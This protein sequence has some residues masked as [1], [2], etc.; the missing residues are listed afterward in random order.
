MG[1]KACTSGKAERDKL[2]FIQSR[3]MAMNQ[4]LTRDEFYADISGTNTARPF[5]VFNEQIIDLTN[6][7]FQNQNKLYL[8]SNQTNSTLQIRQ[9][10]NPGE[11]RHSSTAHSLDELTDPDHFLAVFFSSFKCISGFQSLL[12]NTTDIKYFKVYI[13]YNVPPEKLK[14]IINTKVTLYLLM[15]RD[16]L[17]NMIESKYIPP[18]IHQI[19]TING[20]KT[21]TSYNFKPETYL[22]PAISCAI[23]KKDIEN[24]LQYEL[25]QYQR[26]NLE[27][28]TE[29]EL[30]KPTLLVSNCE[31]LYKYD[32]ASINETIY[33]DPTNWTLYNAQKLLDSGRQYTI[34]LRGGILSD[35]MGLGKT[36]STFSL[37]LNN[38][39]K[40]YP[41]TQV[42]EVPEPVPE[43]VPEKPKRGRKKKTDTSES[44][45]EPLTNTEDMNI[46]PL[47]NVMT[48]VVE[49]K[50]PRK[51]KKIN[52]TTLIEATSHTMVMKNDKTC[53]RATLIIAP[54]RLCKQWYDEINR[55]VKNAT[56]KI[57]VLSTI[58]NMRQCS[59]YDL[60]TADIVIIPANSFTNPNYQAHS[61]QLNTIY[62]H[63]VVIDEA[64]E[65]LKPPSPDQSKRVTDEETQTVTRVTTKHATRLLCEYLLSIEGEYKWLLTGTP[66]AHHVSGLHMYMLYLTQYNKEYMTLSGVDPTYPEYL[67]SRLYSYTTLQGNIYTS[68]I[69]KF[70]RMNTKES[71]K[72]EV[73]IPPIIEE[74]I[75]LKQTPIEKAIYDAA[76]G[77]QKRQ[78]QLCTHVLISEYDASIL[79]TSR[80]LK[81]EDMKD[82]LINHYKDQ[83]DRAVDLLAKKKEELTEVERIKSEQLAKIE[84]SWKILT[85][86]KAIKD[87][88]A[89]YETSR[90]KYDQRIDDCKR[91][92][93]EYEQSVRENTTRYNIFIELNKQFTETPDEPCSIC[94]E[95]MEQ[96]GVSPCGHAFCTE[97]FE[98]LWSK[99]HGAKKIN[100]PMCRIPLAKSDIQTIVRVEP[101]QKEAEQTQINKYGTKMAKLLEIIADVLMR[102]PTNRIILFSQW[103]KM[104]NMVGDVLEEANIRHVYVKGN[105]HVISNAIRRFKLDPS[106]R[107]IMLS[108]ES[109]SSGSNLTEANHIILLDTMNASKE[110]AHAIENQAVGRVSRIG[111]KQQV[112]V[113]RMIMT[114]T[115]EHE[116]YIRNMDV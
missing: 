34:P 95:P 11:T 37:M 76:S 70:I 114:N 83:K 2:Q 58:V 40:L 57:I 48:N 9:V 115:I 36:L 107:I 101:E 35:E 50:K 112:K 77:D 65:I 86:K 59:L 72:Q 116:F 96:I 19:L 24:N 28:M 31:G 33:F 16:Y 80:I 44:K 45:T 54:S 14:K 102:D 46:N 98:H 75:F 94:M 1:S 108:S 87:I 47:T 84:L 22:K 90:A 100:C 104:L 97:C 51:T 18:I 79:G 7:T 20:V 85:D 13:D 81:L 111:Q 106:Y 15:D 39:S 66:F 23:H 38:P 32:I 74:T 17:L 99:A 6:V 69:R 26:N 110:A 88:Q 30:T 5:I 52:N 78:I 61:L 93:A 91:L 10:I 27:W 89:M 63:R 92:I 53:S 8:V 68:L 67:S 21:S 55:Y 71:V 64:H 56:L 12:N 60:A 109:A 113:T 25:Y 42:Q 103:D 4:C 41:P 82:V 29:V 49:V 43:P 105:V 3:V 62:W 73:V